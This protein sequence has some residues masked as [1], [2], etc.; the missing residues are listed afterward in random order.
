MSSLTIESQPLDLPLH[1]PFTIAR[2]SKTM[3]QN[4]WVRVHFEEIT[5]W[6]EAAPS[7]RY[8]QSQASALAALREFEPAPQ[9]TPLALAAVTADFSAR[10]PAE[11]AARCALESALWDWA[12][13]RA[14]QP[15]GRMLGIDPD[16]TPL[17]SFTISIDEPDAIEERVREAAAWPILKVKLGGGEADI[18]AIE[19]LRQVTDRPFRVD[20]NEAWD[21]AEAAE[22]LTWLAGLGCELVEQPLPA[23]SLEAMARL[24]RRSAIPLVA[25]ED[26]TDVAAV[27]EL[28]P[29]FHGINVKLMKTGGV[30]DAVRMIHAARRHGLAVM[31]GCFVESSLGITAAAHLAPLARW[32]DLD[33]AALL[34]AD[35]FCGARVEGGRI[36][37]PTRPGLGVETS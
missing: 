20:A 26:A 30:G 31:L 19:R 24:K 28:A 1:R 17:S 2:G 33:G 25:D 23:G 3:A 27:G 11:S 10:W 16:R 13:K 36:A 9:A 37:I 29:A 21:E 8:G 35:P 22:K 32:A 14:G 15:L 18:V 34:G 12:G 7:P 6:G 4:V 5:G